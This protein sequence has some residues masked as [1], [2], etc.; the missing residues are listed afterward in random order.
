LAA[1]LTNGSVVAIRIFGVE[2]LSFRIAGCR[3]TPK[4]VMHMA[5]IVLTFLTKVQPDKASALRALLGDIANS[6]LEPCLPFSSLKRLH[7]ASLVLNEDATYGPYLVFEN[8]FDGPLEAYLEELYRHSSEGLHRIYSHCLDYPAGSA[9]NREQILSYLR[10]H[11]VQPN[12]Y[13]IGN[14][15]RSVERVLSEDRLRD[16]LESFLDDVVRKGPASQTPGS[17][18]QKVQDFVSSKPALAW[19]T[20]AESRQTWVERFMPRLKIAN[21][22]VLSLLLLPI[23]IPFGI[24]W[25][26]VLLEKEK[27]DPSPARFNINDHVKNLVEHEDRPR[28]VQNHLAHMTTVKPGPFRRATLRGVLWLVNVVARTQ[29]KGKLT[30]IPSIHYAHW[31]LIDNGRRLL[32][33]SNFDGS[34]E[35]YLDD[36]IDKSHYGL[37]GIWSNTASFPRAHLLFLKGATDGTLFK[38]W[39][40]DNQVNTNVWYS[41]YPSLTVETIDNNSAI[42]EQLVSSLD[43]ASAREWLW[44][45]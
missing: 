18:R 22:A 7:F 14:V 36:F 24:I 43:E 25:L 26:L 1:K 45:F 5:Q 20:Q 8:N 2:K 16:N 34:W 21:L 30:G 9:T 19:A 27:R 17:I 23:I 11:I 6:L 15:G 3:N 39:A 33:L 42:R 44:R 35:N 12:A 13:H 4:G 31:S 32:F 41:A 10:K 40:R 28:V 29:N 38:A 37:T